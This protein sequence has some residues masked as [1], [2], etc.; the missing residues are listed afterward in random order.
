[1]EVE[2][3]TGKDLFKELEKLRSEIGNAVILSCSGSLRRVTIFNQIQTQ[4]FTSGP[5]T[6]ISLNGKLDED[7]GI[8]FSDQNG[9][10]YGGSLREGSIIYKS[11]RLF[12]IKLGGNEASLRKGK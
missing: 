12:L 11:A 1:V 5:Y 2:I 7:I 6:I 3:E 9:R 4:S 10:C 8:C